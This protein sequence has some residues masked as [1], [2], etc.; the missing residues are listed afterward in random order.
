VKRKKQIARAL[1]FATA[2]CCRLLDL[3]GERRYTFTVE[4]DKKCEDIA[5]VVTP[6]R[7]SHFTL[8]LGPLFLAESEQDRKNTILHEMLHVL[9]VGWWHLVWMTL[10]ESSM[11]EGER[12]MF[13][14]AVNDQM[15]LYTDRLAMVLAGR[16]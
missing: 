6:R 3:F 16:I 14:S 4:Y 15:E 10:D 11:P 7:R 9:Q 2:E 12:K 5:T 8:T 1:E 13:Q